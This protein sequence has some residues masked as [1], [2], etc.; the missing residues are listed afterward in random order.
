MRAREF[1]MMDAYSSHRDSESL[2]SFYRIM[3]ETFAR[4]FRRCGLDI[5][6]V[7]AD[8]GA[9]G[10]GECHEFM[11]PAE[12]GESCVLSCPGANCGFEAA[13]EA[14]ECHIRPEE[15]T[16]AENINSAMRPLEFIET[17][18]CKSIED[19]ARVSGRPRLRNAPR[20]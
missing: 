10:R 2:D 20:P 19:V 16:D 12:N 15:A 14:A 4:I 1:L 13:D 6:P 5:R 7:L 3:R 18:N 9:I 11:A 8:P 17:P